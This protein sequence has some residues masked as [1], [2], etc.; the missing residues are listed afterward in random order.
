M[1]TDQ[2]T[3]SAPGIDPS[4]VTWDQPARAQATSIDPAH[5]TWDAAPA[6]GPSASTPEAA[7]KPEP[8]L[9]Q[10]LVGA[11][12]E[13][14]R[15]VGLTAR[16]GLEGLGQ[17]AEVVTEPIRK[18]VTDPAMRALGAQEGRPL[19]QTATELADAIGLPKPQD[20][21]ERVVGD[22]TRFLA[23]GAGMAGAAGKVAQLAKPGMLQSAAQTLAANPAEQMVGAVGTGAGAGVSREAG[24][25]DAMQLGAGLAGGLTL[26]G[27]MQAARSG[28]RSA[29]V[30]LPARTQRMEQQIGQALDQAGVNWAEVP[31][32][33]RQGLRA[34][35]EQALGTGQTLDPG[36]VSRLLDFQRVGAT[37]TRGMLSLDPVQI[38][39][40]QNL[41]RMGANASDTGLHGL[42]RVQNENNAALID[43]LN[44]LGAGG[45]GDAHAVGTQAIDTLQR[46]LDAD[47]AAVGVL[48]SQARDS[49]GRSFPLDGS[50]FT[51]RANSLLDEALLGSALPP[52][53]GQHLNRIAAGEVPFTVD[54]AEQLKTAM[55]QLQRASSDGQTRMALGLVRQ[56]LDETPV[57]GLGQ[58]SPAAGV[59][60]GEQA[61]EAFNRA[62][63]ANRDMMQRVE[64]IPGLKAV[65]EGTAAPDDFVQRYVISRGAKVEDTGRLASELRRSDPQSLQAVRG[66]IA[67]HLKTAAIGAAADETGK[68]SA[69]GYNR[70]LMA[71]GP[72]K[73]GQFFSKEEVAQL[74]A[75]GRVAQFA[76]AQPVGSAVNNSNSG[77]LLA[78][79]G[80]DLLDRLASKVPLLGLGPTVSGFARNVQQR[81]A[82]NI[83][84]ALVRKPLPPPRGLPAVTLGTLM[85]S[86]GESAR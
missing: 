10:Q 26:G 31:E 68:F 14:G 42:A 52:S 54:Y 49:A 82:Q 46:G 72:R 25:N 59:Q 22:A 55:G 73:L 38:T 3:P 33:L 56:A 18:L 20:A 50:A 27:L 69:S 13:L 37:P 28:V 41:A 62:R 7:Q 5:V 39:R 75:V 30:L 15:Q 34:E 4:S 66:S 70:A 60:A 16:Y 48:Y 80:L 85:A 61:V 29:S 35:V 23:G 17:A 8:G 9:A 21:T 65:Y 51:S 36:A 11:G 63:L 74:K 53:V 44:R 1:P 19:G 40:E 45:A 12:K 78:G 71:L 67:A 47:R 32:S 24:G 64:A 81:Q 77:A 58:G 79:R 83:A 2:S 57:L 76:T 86:Q 6:Q 84:P 43:S